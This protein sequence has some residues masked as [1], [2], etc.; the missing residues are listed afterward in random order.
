M[1]RKQSI[2]IVTVCVISVLVL[3]SIGNA[4]SLS[5]GGENPNSG[6]YVDKVVYHLIS[7]SD[8]RLLSL[9]AGAIDTIHGAFSPIHLDT[10]EMDPDIGVYNHPRNY[11]VQIWINC[12]DYPLNISGLR[13]AFAFAFDKTQMTPEFMNGPVTVHDSIIP[14]PNSWCIENDLP[15]HYYTNQSELGN[16]ILDTLNFTIDG[17]TGYR[18]APDGTPFDIVLEYWFESGLE[19]AQLGVDALELL[20]IEAATSFSDMGELLSRIDTHGAYDMAIF[21]INHYNNYDVDWMARNFW[22]ENANVMLQNPTNFVNETFDL[23]RDQ[24]INGTSHEDVYEASSEMQTILH[25]NVPML[26]VYA[27]TEYQAYRIDEFTG[28]VEDPSWG[29]AGPWTNLKVHNKIGSSFGGT[30]DV[31]LESAPDTFNIFMTNENSED[32][33]LANLY[34]GLYKFGPDLLKYPDLAE[35]ILIETHLKNPSVPEGQTWM[36]VNIRT[37]ATWSDGMPLTADDVA[38]TFSFLKESIKYGN[39]M[40]TSSMVYTHYS[41]SEVQS[42]YKVKIVFN[43]ESFWEL[44]DALVTPILPEHIFNNDTGIGYD[45]WFTWNPVFGT[46]PHVTCGPFYLSD[47]GSATFE[48]T[49]NMD[50]HWLSGDPPKVLAFD[51]ITY[52]VGTTGHQIEWQVEDE[53]PHEYTVFQNGTPVGTHDWNGSDITVNV[54]GLSI[55]VH[56]FTLQLSDISGHT[57]TSMGLVTVVALGTSDPPDFLVLG[58]AGATGVIILVI[59]IGVYKRR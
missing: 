7:G 14:K 35:D 19:I 11:Y 5:E 55:G 45:G 39:P 30:L 29:I 31:A 23:W 32:L 54:D 43:T 25:E 2:A 46:D 47:H 38:C 4:S 42:P 34:S 51:D 41:S 48:L 53:D 1:K 33:I 21:G 10:M 16:Q 56:N 9:Q 27:R 18:L 3:S 15:W 36:T 49:R 13:R 6:A 50:Y 28:Y 40:S 59:G 57:T 20:H 52:I 58:I 24:L 17:G 8:E 37:D 12:R 44:Q 26:I 22:S